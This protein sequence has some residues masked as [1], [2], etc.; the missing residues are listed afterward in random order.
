MSQTK[1]LAEECEAYAKDGKYCP[2][3][4]DTGTIRVKH[5]TT[6]I[7]DDAD[8]I[9]LAYHE[10]VCPCCSDFRKRLCRAYLELLGIDQAKEQ[11][12]FVLRTDLRARLTEEQNV[13]NPTNRDKIRFLASERDE[14][15]SQKSALESQL[16]TTIL[17]NRRLAEVSMETIKRLESQL[18]ASKFGEFKEWQ[19]TK[20]E[21]LKRI[22]QL[23][24]Q[25]AEARK[26]TDSL[27]LRVEEYRRSHDNILN[28]L[29]CCYRCKDANAALDAAGAFRAKPK[30]EEKL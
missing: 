15:R 7:T 8:E 29:C 26:A 28:G 13:A 30:S 18:A 24:E 2:R 5:G 20:D 19:Y 23:K 21:L 12:L 6:Y 4:H 17:D 11:E 16:A 25:L 1:T 14:L 10:E 3:C 9:E 27:I 22:A